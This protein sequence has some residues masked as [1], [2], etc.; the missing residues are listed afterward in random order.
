MAGR[1]TRSGRQPTAEA[2]RP[3]NNNP[4]IEMRDQEEAEPKSPAAPRVDST[5]RTA[6]NV[7]DDIERQIRRDHQENPADRGRRRS[8]S[9]ARSRSPDR[10]RS[11]GSGPYRSSSRDYRVRSPNDRRDLSR[12]SS[13]SSSLFRRGNGGNE[14]LVRMMLTMQAEQRKQQEITNQI[15]LKALSDRS[16]SAPRPKNYEKAPQYGVERL[17]E[18]STVS[19]RED[20]IDEVTSTNRDQ[21]PG[22]TEAQKIH[23][24]SGH[25]SRELQESW[26]SHRKGFA[27]DATDPR[28][29]TWDDFTA[30]IR[31]QHVA[32][33]LKEWNIRVEIARCRQRDDESP[34]K[35]YQRFETLHRS[36]G[37]ESPLKE[38]AFTYLYRLQPHLREEIQRQNIPWD[39]PRDLSE[40]AERIW[41]N[42]KSRHPNKAAKSS[43]RPREKG[44]NDRQADGDRPRP[45]G[46]S[47]HRP[48][49]SRDKPSGPAPRAPASDP[50]GPES[51]CYTCGGPR[52]N[53]DCPKKANARGSWQSGRGSFGGHG[54]GVPSAH[55][56]KIVSHRDEFKEPFQ[57]NE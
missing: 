34:A 51:G 52:W 4:D 19:K 45:R 5:S 21:R 27:D 17:T 10:G 8:I 2:E 28:E 3:A 22:S 41:M 29:P 11:Q 23:W 46:G 56:R 12:D 16:T 9:T 53:K 55:V 14:D 38:R 42:S 20:W 32:P 1:V 15:L 18:D 54:R 37:N 50:K 13:R 49:E 43:D 48:F 6:E 47:S 26:R 39:D 30:F 44:R 24:A 36:I 33:E 57:G 7:L 31:Q 25:T 40:N 35:Y